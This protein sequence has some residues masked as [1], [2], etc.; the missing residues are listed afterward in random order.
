MSSQPSFQQ[1]E[2]PA[3]LP[4]VP[5][6][7]VSR[8]AALR[9]IGGGLSAALLLGAASR[10]ARADHGHATTQPDVSDAPISVV[11]AWDLTFRRVDAVD[12][13]HSDRALA[14]FGAEGGFQAALA[15]AG[16]DPAGSP[17]F[18]SGGHGSWTTN[19]DGVVVA[20]YTV[21]TYD[22]MGACD[23]ARRVG[24]RASLDSRGSL[25]GAYLSRV[26]D[27]DGNLV[28]LVSGTV[29]GI[30]AGDPGDE[31]PRLTELRLVQVHVRSAAAPAGSP[32]RSSRKAA[33]PGAWPDDHGAGRCGPAPFSISSGTET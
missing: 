18:N 20:A 2:S 31:P 4:V 1:P 16:L 15:P 13:I 21:L 10:V 8:R 19:D 22:E 28:D 23:G 24:I 33:Y 14:T 26:Y 9:G 6:S 12:L 5:A 11:G 29:N 25:T 27:A 30:V 17:R 3:I 7:N 32:R